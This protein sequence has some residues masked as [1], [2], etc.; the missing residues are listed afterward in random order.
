MT[1]NG[2]GQGKFQT[3][4]GTVCVGSPHISVWYSAQGEFFTSQCH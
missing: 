4:K 2:F 1:Q 3:K